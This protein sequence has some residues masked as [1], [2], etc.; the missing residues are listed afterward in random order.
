MSDLI[1]KAK[2][3]KAKR[4]ALM[5]AQEQPED[6]EPTETDDERFWRIMDNPDAWDDCK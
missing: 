3:L 6:D 1:E 2:A 5:Q 4:V